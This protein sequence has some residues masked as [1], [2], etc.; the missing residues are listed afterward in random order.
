MVEAALKKKKDLFTRK[1]D[2]KLRGGGGN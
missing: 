2:L 1:F